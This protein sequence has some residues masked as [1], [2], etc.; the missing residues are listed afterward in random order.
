MLKPRALTALENVDSFQY[1]E[2][3]NL[4]WKKLRALNFSIP[5]AQMVLEIKL[6]KIKLLCYKILHSTERFRLIDR[7]PRRMLLL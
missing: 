7:R 2:K 4:A 6:T 5:G 1:L 3:K